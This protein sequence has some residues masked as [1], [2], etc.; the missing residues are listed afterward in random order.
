M[1][2][3]IWDLIEYI[4]LAFFAIMNGVALVT[5]LPGKPVAAMI[6]L[7]ASILLA[8]VLAIQ[9]LRKVFSQKPK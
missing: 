9:F 4:L 1:K 6:V 5:L 2:V 8:I 7:I 3:S